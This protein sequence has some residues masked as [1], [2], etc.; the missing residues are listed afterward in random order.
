MNESK[1]MTHMGNRAIIKNVGRI[2]KKIA[3]VRNGRETF[4]K[5]SLT[6]V[7]NCSLEH[8][9]RETFSRITGKQFPGFLLTGLGHD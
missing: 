4:I 1:S 7:K 9:K 2:L 6:S 8:G 3:G 5:E